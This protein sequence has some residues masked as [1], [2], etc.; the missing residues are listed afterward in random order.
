MAA[1]WI[2]LHCRACDWRESIHSGQAV[3]WLQSVGMAR[4]HRPPDEEL[5][6]ALLEAGCEQFT[7]PSCQ[8]TGLELLPSD[9]LDESEWEIS[10]TCQGCGQPIPPERLEAIPEAKLCIACQTAEE[11]GTAETEPEYCP[12]CG[13]PMVWR[14]S[15]SSGVTRY[16]MVCGNFPACRGQLKR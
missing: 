14:H 7:C 4:V 15:Q 10:V 5:L 8:A 9:D 11:A 16:K 1:W 3:E 2:D 6:P 12:R 13:T